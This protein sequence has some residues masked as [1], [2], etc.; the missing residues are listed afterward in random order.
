MTSVVPF[1][2]IK[3]IL[4][5]TPQLPLDILFL[6]VHFL[7]NFGVFVFFTN[8]LRMQA[9][10]FPLIKYK[11]VCF[12]WMG[13]CELD[14]FLFTKN[15]SGEN[16]NCFL[17]LKL[18]GCIFIYFFIVVNS[19][20]KFL[21]LPISGWAEKAKMWRFDHLPTIPI[22]KPREHPPLPFGNSL[23]MKHS[24]ENLGMDKIW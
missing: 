21:N 11:C 2:F 10:F 7:R 16:S 20:L 13:L 15:H 9:Q 23:W 6:H 8:K 22:T 1:F 14:D 5:P 3:V 17:Q 4:K 24:S 12:G 18:I 19:S